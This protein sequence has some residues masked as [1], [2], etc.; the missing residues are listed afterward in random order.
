M[1]IC[2]TILE[3]YWEQ[4]MTSN[5]KDCA[6]LIQAAVWDANRCKTLRETSECF[7]TF[8]TCVFSSRTRSILA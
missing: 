5:S 4:E 8:G 1:Y 3:C 2:I 6:S 7:A